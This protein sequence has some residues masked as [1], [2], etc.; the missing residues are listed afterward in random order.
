MKKRIRLIRTIGLVLSFFSVH[1]LLAQPFTM[2]PDITPIELN[3]YEFKPAGNEKAN[4]RLNVTD[5]TQDKDTQYYFA[6]GFSIYS[7]AY[8]GVTLQ[9]KS[10]N[11]EVSLFKEN[12]LKESQGGTT[13]GQ[14]HWDAKFKTEGDFGIRVIA[15]TIPS[16]Y[17]LVVWNGKD[18]EP[19][20]PS[21]FVYK[22]G[23]SDGGGKAG[24]FK[25]NLMVII[26]AVLGVAV[27]FLFLKLKKRK[28]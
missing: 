3:L 17:A 15:K 19:E 25:K 20:V 6:K 24:F 11:V 27:I 21:P 18:V 2:N 10:N 7:A 8:V 13:N 22:E 23:G 1:P 28:S 5:V 16:T 12:W 4:G 26:I 14:G 9:D